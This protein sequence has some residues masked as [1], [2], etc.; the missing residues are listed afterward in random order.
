MTLTRKRDWKLAV[1]NSD[2]DGI[3]LQISRL[4]VRYLPI[5]LCN[6]ENTSLVHSSPLDTFPS[7]SDALWH[8]Q[9]TK[10]GSLV[11]GWLWLGLYVQIVTQQIMSY[12]PILLTSHKAMFS[13]LLFPFHFSNTTCTIPLSVICNVPYNG[14]IDVDATVRSHY[15]IYYNWTLNS[16]ERWLWSCHIFHVY[17][18]LLLARAHLSIPKGQMHL[19]HAGL[20]WR[21]A[22]RFHCDDTNCLTI[23]KPNIVNIEG[24]WAASSMTTTS[25][26]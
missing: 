5:S 12:W 26:N 25:E 20:P 13:T 7:P 1:L 22:P 15:Q 23:G 21:C 9:T 6:K 8:C 17:T 18:F 14:I 24:H 4:E 2:G 19:K 11:R 16:A 3:N 10:Q